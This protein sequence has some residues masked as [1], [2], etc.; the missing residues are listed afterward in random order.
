MTST[1]ILVTIICSILGSGALTT[2]TSWLLNRFADPSKRLEKAI[3]DS[4]TIRRLEL[5]IYRQT[6]FLPTTDRAMHE[7]QLEAGAEYLRLGGNGSGHARYDQL[8]SD[9]RQRLDSDDWTY[10]H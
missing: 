1:P 10:N 5:E 7:H 9:Y 4:P 6:L 3:S 8:E 2:L